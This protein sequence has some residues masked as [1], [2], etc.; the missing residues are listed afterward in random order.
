V[1]GNDV[2]RADNSSYM[3]WNISNVISTTDMFDKCLI[4]N[5]NKPNPQIRN[6]N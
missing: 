5:K 1:W 2:G 6:P 3:A 4:S